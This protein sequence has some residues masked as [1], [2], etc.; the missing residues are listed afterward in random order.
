MKKILIITIMLILFIL[1]GCCEKEEIVSVCTNTWYINIYPINRN[2]D[3]EYTERDCHKYND[4]KIWDTVWFAF[5]WNRTFNEPVE[6]LVID[7]I[8]IWYEKQ[9]VT[10][11]HHTMINKKDCITMI[12]WYWVEPQKTKDDMVIQIKEYFKRQE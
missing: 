2:Y 12:N 8:K 7:W 3:Y 9:I 4:I 11:L 10:E 6:Y 5:L 1:Y